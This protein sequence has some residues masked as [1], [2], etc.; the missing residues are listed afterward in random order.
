MDKNSVEYL[1]LDAQLSYKSIDSYKGSKTL[2]K[3]FKAIVAEDA[4]RGFVED[5]DLDCAYVAQAPACIGN[6]K[7][8][9]SFK[10]NS[11]TYQDALM[12]YFKYYFRLCKTNNIE[13]KQLFNQ[14]EKK[15]V[16]LKR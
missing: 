3:V 7:I 4:F 8:Q 1:I 2:E 5:K 10:C 15:I 16:E 12:G 6:E 13:G 9:K 14:L 11:I